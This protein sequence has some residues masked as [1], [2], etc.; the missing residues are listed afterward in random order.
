M[1]LTMV[2]MSCMETQIVPEQTSVEVEG[3]RGHLEK[4][5]PAN[6]F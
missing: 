3:I 2:F 4:S 5:I 6:F 1:N